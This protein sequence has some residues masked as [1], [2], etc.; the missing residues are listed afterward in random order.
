MRTEGNPTEK[1]I[2]EALD[3]MMEGDQARL[4]K[5]VASLGEEKPLGQERHEGVAWALATA[6]IRARDEASLSVLIESGLSEEHRRK[7]KL[8]ARRAGPLKEGASKVLAKAAK[9]GCRG[10]I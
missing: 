5:A 2:A 4:Q 3:A 7:A 10:A 6:A 9:L 1:V 8:S